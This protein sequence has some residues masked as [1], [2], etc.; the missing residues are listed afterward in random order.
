MP[1]SNLSKREKE[2]VSLLLQGKSNKQIALQLGIAE[3]TVEF[4]LKNIYN[5]LDVKS[6]TEAIIKIGKSTGLIRE[7]LRESVVDLIGG[8]VDNGGTFSLWKQFPES[9][10]STA[11]IIK[12]E[13]KMKNRLLSYFLGGL[14]FGVAFWYYFSLIGHFTNTLS[15]DEENVLEVWAFLSIEFLLIFGVWLIPTLWPTIYEFR[16]SK[17]ISLS[18]FA[19]IVMWMSAL[20]GYYA[21]YMVLLA[22]VGLPNMDYYLV[23]RHHSPTFWQDWAALFPKLILFN[24]LKWTAVGTIVGGFAGLVTSSL[25]SFW[26]KKT[27]TVLSA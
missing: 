2:V 20:L 13:I 27:H 6:R 7:D 18:V 19:V 14:I 16:R 1:S 8:Q 23:F 24:Y 5:K 9:R 12:K 4:H 11:S 25:Y 22:F 26:I 17:R 10:I 15:I 3:S 21:N